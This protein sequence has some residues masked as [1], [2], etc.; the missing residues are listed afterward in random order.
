MSKGAFIERDGGFFPMDDDGREIMTAS[1]GK[2][3][4]LS[5]HVP[6]NIV[7][8]RLLFYL[9][10]ML[11]EGGAWKGDRE[12]LLDYLK[13]ATRHVSTIIDP[14]TGEVFYKT[15]SISFESMDQAAFRR[16]FDRAVFIACERLLP[17]Q[18]GEALRDEIN[19]A[20]EGDI[21]EQNYRSA[22]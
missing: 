13:I 8:H 5:V 6:R 1:K 3:V 12:D 17:G 9:I 18:D 22:A 21:G 15:K 2:R 20:V 11:C 7:H 10:N 19:V 4:M 16:F 14:A